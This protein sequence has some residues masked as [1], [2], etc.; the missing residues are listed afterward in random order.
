MSQLSATLSYAESGITFYWSPLPSISHFS[1]THVS[2]SLITGRCL[3]YRWHWA[4]RRK[5]FFCCIYCVITPCNL[6]FCLT[7]TWRWFNYRWPWVTLRRVFY[8]IPHPYPFIHPLFLFISCI[9]YRNN[10][11]FAFFALCRKMSQLS[12]TLSYAASGIMSFLVLFFIMFGAFVQMAYLMFYGVLKDFSNFIRAAETMFS[13]MLSEYLKGGWLIGH[14][15][16][17]VFNLV[18]LKKKLINF[19]LKVCICILKQQKL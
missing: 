8:P 17:D 16:L 4:T 5:A 18:G 6:P 1:H 14:I 19:T 13:L 2:F 15:K 9:E 11:T 3:N 12:A 7:F 10:V